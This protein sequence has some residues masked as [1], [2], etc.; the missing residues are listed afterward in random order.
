MEQERFAAF[1]ED[2]MVDIAHVE[3]M[4][5]GADMLRM[6]LEFEAN[7]NKKFRSK[8]NLQSGGFSIEFIDEEN[9]DTRSTMK[10]F[11]RFTI[12]IPIFGRSSNAY[13]IEARLKYREKDG[14]LT[15]WYELIRPDRVFDAAVTDELNAVRERTGVPVIF[16]KPC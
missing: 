5:S 14:K 6:A 8:T 7:S 12:G 2:N 13:P 15:F 4:P 1:L 16:G 11:E 10:V 3:N 9:H